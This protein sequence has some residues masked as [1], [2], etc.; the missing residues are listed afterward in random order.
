MPNPNST[1][2]LHLC[3]LLLIV[4]FA[5]AFVPAWGQPKRGLPVRQKKEKYYLTKSCS[6][7][8]VW[9]EVRLHDKALDEKI[10][11]AIRKAVLAY[12]LAPDAAPSRCDGTMEYSTEFKALYAKNGLI[13][14]YLSAF[15]YFK[16][17]PHGYREFSTLN[18]DA[19]TGRRI[20]FHDLIDS[21][22]IDAVD[23]LIMRR[24]AE[25]LK[26]FTSDLEQ[27]RQQLPD[28][29]FTINDKGIDVLFRSDM[30]VLSIV[31]IPFSYEELGPYVNK[32]GLLRPVY[33]E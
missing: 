4:V 25:R 31:E 9:D 18:F 30:Y 11:G 15:T 10:N 23:T 33:Q 6:Y 7:I 21:G 17:T 29:A 20:G 12:K 3:R 5:L 1:R 2:S 14:Y 8:L 28:L 13:S 26:S 16:E 27:W 32:S 24:L 19:A 22:R